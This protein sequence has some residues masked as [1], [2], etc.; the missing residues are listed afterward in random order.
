MDGHIGREKNQNDHASPDRIR[1]KDEE[2]EEVPR[3]S[4]SESLDLEPIKSSSSDEGLPLL[5]I[6]DE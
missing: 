6:K 5:R 3:E 1:I 4:S 2:G